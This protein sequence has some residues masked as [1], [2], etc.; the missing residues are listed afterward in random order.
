MR[1]QIE[2]FAHGTDLPILARVPYDPAIAR[3]FSSEGGPAVL[4]DGPGGQAL[5]DA[6]AELAATVGEL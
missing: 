5:A 2:A 3:A 6:V 4:P 1:A